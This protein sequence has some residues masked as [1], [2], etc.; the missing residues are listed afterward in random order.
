[1]TFQYSSSSRSECR[2][3]RHIKENTTHDT[4]FQIWRYRKLLNMLAQSR[5]A[6]TSCITL[7]LPPRKC[8]RHLAR[9]LAQ[10]LEITI[11]VI[12][13]GSA[14]DLW[15]GNRDTNISMERYV[16]GRVRNGIQYQK[17]S[18]SVSF[19]RSDQL[20]IR[21]GYLVLRTLRFETTGY[22]FF[23]P[24]LPLSKSS[25]CSIAVGFVHY[26]VR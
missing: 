7:I 22:P 5:G 25:N 12:L 3:P 1:M 15:S 9:K 20:S 2:T 23:L 18:Q 10:M 14:A 19:P 17:S 26:I 16:D 6:G 24:L 21:E 8:L 4:G 11:A 13:Q